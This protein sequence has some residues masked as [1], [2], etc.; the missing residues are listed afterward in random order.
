MNDKISKS[1]EYFQEFLNNNFKQCNQE[2]I[3]VLLMLAYGHIFDIFTPNQ[4]SQVLGID[5]ND[6]YDAINSWSIYNFRKLFLIA[7]FPEVKKLIDDKKSCYS[8]QNENYSLC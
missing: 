8:L 3:E 5:K 2:S 4:F 1:V 7:G 6:I